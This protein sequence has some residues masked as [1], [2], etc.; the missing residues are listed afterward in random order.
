MCAQM[1]SCIAGLWERGSLVL[2][3]SFYSLKLT[4]A[5]GVFDYYLF[6]WTNNFVKYSEARIQIILEDC[7]A[8][9]HHENTFFNFQRFL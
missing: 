4:E 5:C 7:L 9:G 8:M 1:N 3:I 2:N 6:V